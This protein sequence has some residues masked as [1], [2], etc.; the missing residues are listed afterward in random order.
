MKELE[1]RY[2]NLAALRADARDHLGKG[3]A[4]VAGPSD[5]QEREPCRLTLHHPQ[6]GDVLQLAA[7]AVWLSEPPNPPGVGVQLTRLDADEK[8]RLLDFTQAR[9]GT[10]PRESVRPARN[11]HERVRELGIA[12]REGL[13]RTGSL[14][15]RV[16]LERRFGSSV[17][18]ALLRNP[19]VTPAEVTRM[20][21][22]GSLPTPLVN[23]IVNNAGWVADA[24]VRRA[25]LNNPR[26]GGAQLVRLLQ[27]QP[28]SE[29]AR[30][31]RQSGLRTSARMAAKRLLRS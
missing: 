16:A 12:E 5:L 18:E 19:S 2:A 23:V 22:S 15:E 8:E 11:L 4:F 14:P 10:Q 24:G 21:S 3:R 20:A 31:A 30:L 27:N 17:W 1:L 29:L 28:Q 26:V 7:E 13:A 25:L 6:G 9:P